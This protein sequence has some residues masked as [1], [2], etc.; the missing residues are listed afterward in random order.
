MGS[1][2]VQVVS[3]GSPVQY[4]F[5]PP[6]SVFAQGDLSVPAGMPVNDYALDTQLGGVVITAL[7]HIV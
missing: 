4:I 7:L 2:T 6:G 3:A 5:V 1:V